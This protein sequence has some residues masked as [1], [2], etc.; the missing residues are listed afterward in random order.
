MIEVLSGICGFVLAFIVFALGF[1]AGQKYQR[2][3]DPVELDDDQKEKIRKERE[4]LER[5]QEAFWQLTGY[6]ADIAYGVVDFP[7]EGSN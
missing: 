4:R 2:P 5:E 7:K 3:A 1:S 6:S